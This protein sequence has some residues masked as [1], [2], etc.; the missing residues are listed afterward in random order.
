MGRL[1]KSLAA[2]VNV[3]RKEK[4]LLPR[5]VSYLDRGLMDLSLY[6]IRV[7]SIVPCFIL[8]TNHDRH[9]SGY[10]LFCLSCILRVLTTWL[11]YYTC[12]KLVLNYIV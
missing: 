8:V 4:G 6:C 7:I 1:A 3:K 9:F 12:K 11:T 10:I 5:P 2:G